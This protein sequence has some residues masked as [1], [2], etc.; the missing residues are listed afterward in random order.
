MKHYRYILLTLVCTS[1]AFSSCGNHS[2]NPGNNPHA[3][4]AVGNSAQPPDSIIVDS[5]PVPQNT[6]Q[7]HYPDIARKAGIEGTVWLR[8]LVS[9]KGVVKDVN[10]LRVNS[11]AKNGEPATT[12]QDA[13]I[14]AVQNWTFTPA[15]LNGKPVQVWVAIPFHFKLDKEKKK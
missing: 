6:V 8:V 14:D 12:L 2:G 15:M 1:L 5:Q 9:D 10:V 3:N 7:P 13:A 11:N 4:A